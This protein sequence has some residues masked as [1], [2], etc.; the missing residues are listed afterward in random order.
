MSGLVVVGASLA[1]IR[2]AEEARASGWEGPITLVGD[3]PHAPYDRPSLSKEF[4]AEGLDPEPQPLAAPEWYAE[5][6]V[7]LALGERATALDPARGVLTT[8]AGER[9]FS[10]AV[11]ATGSAPVRLPGTEGLAG[12]VSLRTQ[13][14]AAEVRRALDARAKI[15]VIGGGFIGAEVASAARKRGLSPTIIEGAPVPLVR[16]V[17]E[18]MG[19]VLA[20][21]H[22]QHGTDLRC[23]IGVS[24][25]IGDER[26]EAVTLADGSLVEAD[27]VV[28]GIGTRPTTGWLEGSGLELENGLVCDSS[29]RSS[30]PNVWA[31]GDIANWHNPLFGRQMRIEHF[32]AAAEQGARAGRNAALEHDPLPYATVPYFWSDWY[33][34]R[35]QFAGVATPEFEVV[36]GG[37]DE[38]HFVVLYRDGDRL[39]GVLTLNGQRHVMKYRKRIA[40]GGLFADAL[41][42]AAARVG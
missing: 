9:E 38:A 30:A 10:R 41:A 37:L 1:G 35:I 26:V 13:E 3:E 19:G 40:D 21:L 11:I 5:R 2:A 32:T 12:V 24:G 31:A 25:F 42:F 15:A 20:Q 36:S 7:E 28:V 4:L 22:A 18:E 8:T 23:G 39:A 6:G 14:D 16:A 17:G 33:G 27:L 34:H 29:L